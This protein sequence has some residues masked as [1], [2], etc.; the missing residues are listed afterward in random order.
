MTDPY[1]V[2]NKLVDVMCSR[3]KPEIFKACARQNENIRCKLM[4][5]CIDNIVDTDD[6]GYPVIL[7]ELK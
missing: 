1:S 6:G 3:C 2:Y 5:Q 7:P 4:I